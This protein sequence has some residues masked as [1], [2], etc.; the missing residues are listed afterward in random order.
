M[1]IIKAMAEKMGINNMSD[2]MDNWENRKKGMI[3]D[4]CM[5]FCIKQG[6]NEKII[7]GRCRRHAPTMKGW[8]VMYPTD[9]CGSH[10]LDENKISNIEKDQEI[11]GDNN[12]VN[13]CDRYKNGFICVGI[14]NG[15]SKKINQRC[16]SC[17]RFVVQ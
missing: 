10:K 16:L 14:L 8:P 2:Q 15:I 1:I 9:W 5:Y 13:P 7:I 6:D 3:C 12:F 4:T 11:V 17:D